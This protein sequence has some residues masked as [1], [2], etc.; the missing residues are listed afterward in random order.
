MP[1]STRRWG[2]G[3]KRCLFSVFIISV[4]S[5][6]GPNDVRGEDRVK[7]Y[8]DILKEIYEFRKKRNPSYSMMAFSRDSGFKSYHMSDILR[9]RYGLSIAS[10]D[11]VASKL[12]MEPAIREEFLTLVALENSVS[13]I[14]R[15]VATER[16]KQL[17]FEYDRSLSHEEF[18]VISKWYYL[19]IYEFLRP[20]KT[21]PSVEF[22]QSEIGVTKSEV[23]DAIEKLTQLRAIEVNDGNLIVNGQLLSVKAYPSSHIRGFHKQM[24]GKALDSVE[25]VSFNERCLNSYN[26]YLTEQEYSSLI[27]ELS[28]FI[29]HSIN[30][31]QKERKSNA[32]LY[33]INTQIFPLAKSP[34]SE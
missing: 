22:I 8:K 10:A 16:L 33:S 27:V 24:I 29:R 1:E 17:E 9:G 2:Y 3:A 13:P 4:I 11:K 6:I 34:C 5:G 19:A 23:L 28:A 25:S 18:C 20:F 31:K 26:L 7:S 12:R 21:M 30:E 15:Q 32:R 14:D